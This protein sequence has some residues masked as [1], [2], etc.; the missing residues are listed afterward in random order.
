MVVQ[1]EKNVNFIGAK[2]VA[3]LAFFNKEFWHI[4]DYK[5][6]PIFQ[7]FCEVNDIVFVVEVSRR[8]RSYRLSYQRTIYW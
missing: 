6:M 7:V 5:K 8:W 4:G 1:N 3:K 2:N